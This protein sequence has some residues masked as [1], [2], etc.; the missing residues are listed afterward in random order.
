MEEQAFS[1]ALEA[2]RKGKCITIMDSKTREAKTDLF[3]PTI[4]FLLFL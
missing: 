2:L 3:F 4:F 1:L